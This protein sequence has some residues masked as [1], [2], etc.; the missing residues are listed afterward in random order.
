MEKSFGELSFE[1]LVV[2]YF[3]KDS[4]IY[5]KVAKSQSD[6]V[7]NNNSSIIELK[8]QPQQP[9]T[10]TAHHPIT[11]TYHSGVINPL[12]SANNTSDTKESQDSVY[13]SRISI[14]R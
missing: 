7:D 3:K 1:E 11:S 6:G 2:N 9:P 5:K 10:T 8:T 4:E 13:I 12:A 14:S